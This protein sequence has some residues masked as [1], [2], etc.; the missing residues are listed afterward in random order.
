VSSQ[1]GGERGGGGGPAN[2]CGTVSAELC[3]LSPPRSGNLMYA[4][5]PAISFSRILNGSA[6]FSFV[7][8]SSFCTTETCERDA[9]CPISTG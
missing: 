9:A 4:A 6:S 5:S 2:T 3:T 7:S 8:A 1:Y